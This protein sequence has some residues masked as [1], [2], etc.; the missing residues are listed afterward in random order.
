MVYEQRTGD[1]EGRTC[2]HDEVCSENIVDVALATV[3]PYATY[4]RSVTCAWL[5]EYVEA[6]GMHVH[7]FVASK[8]RMHEQN[9][10]P[11]IYMCI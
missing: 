3:A 4:I 7:G 2:C 1:G 5:S 9:A 6:W 11:R 10:L 8:L